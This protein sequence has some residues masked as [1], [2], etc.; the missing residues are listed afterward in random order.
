QRRLTN[1][2]GKDDYPVWH[3]DGKRILFVSER[4]G[5]YDLYLL[6]VEAK[7]GDA[8]GKNAKQLPADVEKCLSRAEDAM[9]TLAERA[10]AVKELVGLRDRR[11]M[12]RLLRILPGH[13]DVLALR[14]VH[15]VAAL[16]YPEALSTLQKYKQHARNQDLSGKLNAAIREAI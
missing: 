11:C 12:P 5:K 2:P 4:K 10:E 16:D 9:I 15:A 6:D 14:I 7:S 8:D 3:P 13:Y 1:N